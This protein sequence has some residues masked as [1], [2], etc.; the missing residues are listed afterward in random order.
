MRFFA[1]V[2]SFTKTRNFV[3]L[4]KEKEATMKNETKT[5]RKGYISTFYQGNRFP[6]IITVICAVLG[7]VFN[8]LLAVFIQRLMD[9]AIQKDT[10]QLIS[11]V[12]ISASAF[13]VF[14]LPG[15]YNARRSTASITAPCGSTKSSYSAT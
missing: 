2:R 14:L 12:I 7:A 11:T 9:A 3:I 4:C 15:L 8:I 5:L 6:Y 10:T 1:T 13:G